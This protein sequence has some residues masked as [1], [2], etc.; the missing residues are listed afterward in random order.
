M[1]LNIY[2]LQNYK[3]MSAC[4]TSEI[5]IKSKDYDEFDIALKLGSL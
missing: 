1:L 5:W 2:T 4:T 3:H